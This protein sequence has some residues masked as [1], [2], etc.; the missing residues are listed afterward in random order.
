MRRSSWACRPR[1]RTAPP[2]LASCLAVASAPACGSSRRSWGPGQTASPAWQPHGRLAPSLTMYY[3]CNVQKSRMFAMRMPPDVLEALRQAAAED[4][5]PV[6][7]LALKILVQRLTVGNCFL[8]NRRSGRKALRAHTRRRE[9]TMAYVRFRSG[10]WYFT[11]T[12][13]AGVRR[14]V[15]S[16]ARTKTEAVRLAGEYERQQERTRFGL[17]DAAPAPMRFGDLVQ[18][19]RET[20]GAR[21]RSNSSAEPKLKSPPPARVRR[22]PSDRHHPGGPRTVPADE[23]AQAG[24]L[25]RRAPASAAALDVHLRPRLQA[26]PRA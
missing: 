6:N 10:H 19:W 15:A 2:R 1:G 14:E 4:M 11:V 12:D 24:D 22:A 17:E 26:F 7:Q 25:E 21:S 5:R 3:V 16:R 23:G 13:A 9:L 20:T 8:P 18:L